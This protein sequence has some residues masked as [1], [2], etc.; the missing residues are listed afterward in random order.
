METL[1]PG[2]VRNTASERKGLGAPNQDP[3]A[4]LEA[5]TVLPQAGIAT[6]TAL[7]GLLSDTRNDLNTR[8]KEELGRV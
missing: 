6:L 8:L 2:Q 5:L 3:L 4:V 1:R 7:R